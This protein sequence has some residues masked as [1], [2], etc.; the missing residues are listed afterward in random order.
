MLSIPIHLLS[1]RAARDSALQFWQ[2]LQ[3]SGHTLESLYADLEDD[4]KAEEWVRDEFKAIIRTAVMDPVDS[5][6]N[7]TCPD[8][9]ALAEALDPGDYIINFNWDSL[10]ADAL[11]YASALWFP[12]TGF[13][14]TQAYPVCNFRPK[15]FNLQS[16]VTLL[17]V[18]GAVVLFEPV[19]SEPYGAVPSRLLYVQSD[20]YNTFSGL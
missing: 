4:Q 19:P 18:H 20:A 13:G 8:H 15:H 16:L 12:A 2:H 7:G 3:A 5:T 6:A 14:Y 10:M 17:H 9:R 11:Y 1:P